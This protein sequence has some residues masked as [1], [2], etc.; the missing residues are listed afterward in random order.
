MQVILRYK[1]VHEGCQQSF[2][3]TKGNNVPLAEKSWQAVQDI[4]FG[5]QFILWAVADAE[6][7]KLHLQ[8]VVNAA[9]QR[10]HSREWIIANSKGNMGKCKLYLQNIVRFA[11]K[12][13]C[14]ST[15]KYAKSIAFR[16]FWTVFAL[17]VVGEIGGNPPSTGSAKKFAEILRK[18]RLFAKILQGFCKV[19]LLFY[20]ET[21]I[22]AA[23]LSFRSPC[24]WTI[25]CAAKA[26]LFQQLCQSFNFRAFGWSWW[27]G[28]RVFI[29]PSYSPVA[30]GLHEYFFLPTSR[31]L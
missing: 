9:H 15:A 27:A 13:P 22:F 29:T 2:E 26:L 7:P 20:C 4:Q 6:R 12:P 18:F 3:S 28:I 14:E 25:Q 17:Q 11:A 19:F 23:F 16:W 5:C 24:D 10:E 1:C 31:N 30:C 8:P 21:H